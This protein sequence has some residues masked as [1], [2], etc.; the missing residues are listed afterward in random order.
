LQSGSCDGQGFWFCQLQI[1]RAEG[2]W[3]YFA[4]RTSQIANMTVDLDKI[5]A[6]VERVAESHGLELVESEFRGG[7]KARMLRIYI[8]KPT[9]VTHADCEA[10]S[11]E[12]ST[13]LDVEDVVPGGPYT[14][15]VSSPGLDRKLLK[16]VDYER[17]AGNM[18]TVQTRLPVAGSRRHQGRLEGLRDG[19]IALDLKGTKKTPAVRLEI[20]L[21][22][23]LVA[24]LV[25]EF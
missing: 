8:D 13:I 25:P 1:Q 19:R 20:D 23:V 12:V 6:I 15:E 11:R 4:N 17:F 7:G 2:S 16:P 10:V 22:N 3:S 5:R 18:I 24:K 9:G 21:A 14:L